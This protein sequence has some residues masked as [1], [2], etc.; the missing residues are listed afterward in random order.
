MTE[1][2]K[3]VSF[4][5]CAVVVGALAWVARPADPGRGVVDDAGEL[6]FV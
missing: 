2:L 5:A 4:V 3:T 6:F 1:P